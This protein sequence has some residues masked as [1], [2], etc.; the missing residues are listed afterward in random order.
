MKSVLYSK[1]SLLRKREKGRFAFIFLL[2]GKERNFLILI[3]SFFLISGTFF[4][5]PHIAM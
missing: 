1:K 5:Y 4:P 3:F 2:I